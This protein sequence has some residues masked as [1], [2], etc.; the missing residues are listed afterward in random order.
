MTILYFIF[1][2][3][4]IQQNRNMLHTLFNWFDYSIQKFPQNAI[5]THQ[6][7]FKSTFS[8]HAPLVFWVY[9]MIVNNFSVHCTFSQMYYVNFL[10]EASITFLNT[11]G[12]I[13]FHCKN[14]STDTADSINLRRKNPAVFACLCQAAGGLHSWVGNQRFTTYSRLQ[15]LMRCTFLFRW[16]PCRRGSGSEKKQ[17]NSVCISC[18]PS[19]DTFLWRV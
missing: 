16:K 15:F 2:Q 1:S 7:L 13:F 6:I 3:L 10:E 14:K 5:A 12:I 19:P 18:K 17:K 11:L 8:S 4:R 9:N